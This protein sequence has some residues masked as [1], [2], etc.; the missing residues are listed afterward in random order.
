[1]RALTFAALLLLAACGPTVGDPCTTTQ[2]CGGQ[3]CL[4]RDFTPGGYCAM[5]CDLADQNTCPAGTICVREVLGRNLPGCMKTCRDGRDC[6]DGYVCK[7][8][9]DSPSTICVGPNGI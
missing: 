3:T 2:E 8:E 7:T 6:R 5:G 1:M 4:N 9:K